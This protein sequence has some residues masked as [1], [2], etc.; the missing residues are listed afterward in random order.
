MT[1]LVLGTMSRLAE[2]TTGIAGYSS[3]I[4]RLLGIELLALAA[5]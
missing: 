3:T 1:E 5:Y 4:S 2:L